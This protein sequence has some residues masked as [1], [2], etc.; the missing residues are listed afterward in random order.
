MRK[1]TRLE[2]LARIAGVSTATISRALNDSPKVND[3][4]KRRIW[5]LAREHNYAFRPHMPTILSA[6]AA[7]IVLVIPMLPGREGSIKD[8]FFLELIAGV[9]DAA[10]QNSCDVLVSY[11]TPDSFDDLSGLVSANRRDGVIFLGQSFL[12]ERFNRLADAGG[13]FVVWGAE[14]P[15][16]RYCSV[17]SDNFRGG[18]KATNHLLRLGR[19]RIAF[20]GDTDA[21]EVGQ[22]YLGYVDALEEAGIEVD[23][24]LVASAQFELESAEAAVGTMLAKKIE[25]DAIFASSDM[26]A[27]GATRAVKRFGLIVPKDIAV[28]GY[29]NIQISRY[30]SPSITTISQDLSKAG[31]VLVSKLLSSTD[32]REIASER[33]PTDLIVRESC[34]S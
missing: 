4:T 26:I 31:R 11:Q 33:L 29:D 34:G 25:F 21:P 14:M 22:R 6:A 5:L 28:V 3:E 24:D 30:N 19:R 12:H 20:L 8:P 10:Q 32:T 27:V 7:K 16:Q 15:G 18:Q 13:H 23:H 1:N 17:G 9:C 2:D